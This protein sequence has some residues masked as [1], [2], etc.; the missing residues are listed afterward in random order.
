MAPRKARRV[1]PAPIPSDSRR[2]LCAP[3]GEAGGG[4]CEVHDFEV[5]G[6]PGQWDEGAGVDGRGVGEDP[7]TS[8]NAGRAGVCLLLP[9]L[10][11]E[12]AVFLLGRRGGGADWMGASQLGRHE[13]PMGRFIEVIG[14][15][16][17][18]R[19]LI[20][21]SSFGTRADVYPSPQTLDLT[22]GINI[23]SY[24]LD[25][26]LPP[27][28]GDAFQPPRIQHLVLDKTKITD[29]AAPAISECKDLRALHLAKTKISSSSFTLSLFKLLLD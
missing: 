26:L 5:G 23:N 14:R 1:R 28:N 9:Q 2:V 21:T 24:H 7:A 22:C 11:G 4:A 10:G 17:I 20:R 3:R 18:V 13:Q 15:R 29:E 8:G 19:P 27:L 16:C 12:S 6:D 25:G